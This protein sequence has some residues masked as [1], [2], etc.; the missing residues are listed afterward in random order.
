MTKNKY[1]SR[2]TSTL[3]I[4]FDAILSPFLNSHQNT[5]HWCI[6][7]LKNIHHTSSIV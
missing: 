6:Q 3:D 1:T 7:S 4:Y 2:Y 5:R